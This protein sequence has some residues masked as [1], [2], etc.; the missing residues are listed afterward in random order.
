MF[1]KPAPAARPDG[2][3]RPAVVVALL[4]AFILLLT[5]RTNAWHEAA[6]DTAMDR[7]VEVVSGDRGSR[8]FYEFARP[9]ALLADDMS[10]SMSALLN[11]LE[12]M[13]M[14]F[15]YMFINGSEL[16]LLPIYAVFPY[17]KS[18]VA[19]LNVPDTVVA[20]VSLNSSN[21]FVAL[22][23]LIPSRNQTFAGANEDPTMLMPA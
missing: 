11:G 5:V 9:E 20:L 6:H 13:I 15:M 23:Y 19:E 21:S 7:Q 12:Y 14:K 17:D 22:V 2:L 18:V 10:V 3:H 8:F 1:G 16:R 4:A